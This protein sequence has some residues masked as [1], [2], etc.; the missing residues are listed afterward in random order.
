METLNNVRKFPAFHKRLKEFKNMG[1]SLGNLDSMVMLYLMDYITYCG[2]NKR[3][4]GNTIE[5]S[6]QFKIELQ[7]ELNIKPG[8]LNNVLSKLTSVGIMY[9]IKNGMYQFNPYLAA[10][11]SDEDI[12]WI[13]EFGVFRDCITDLSETFRSKDEIIKSVYDNYNKTSI[14]I[15]DGN[16]I[17]VNPI[18]VWDILLD[19]KIITKDEFQLLIRDKYIIK[20]TTMQFEH[21]DSILKSVAEERIE[22]GNV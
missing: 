5:I 9:K 2:R 1:N 15:R 12:Y 14:E 8:T 10:K 21:L 16:V 13:R 19:M 3:Y 18:E 6:R 4:G 11:G 17:K 22:G 20:D 7:N